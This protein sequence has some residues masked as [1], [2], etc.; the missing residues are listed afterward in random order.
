[1]IIF[2]F[3]DEVIVVDFVDDDYDDNDDDYR[4]ERASLFSVVFSC[5]EPLMCAQTSRLIASVSPRGGSYPYPALS[6]LS[7]FSPFLYIS[8]SVSQGGF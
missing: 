1:M 2:F 4:G 3:F 7:S 5:G 6:S 8:F